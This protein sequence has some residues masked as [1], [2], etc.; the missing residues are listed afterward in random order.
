MSRMK[1]AFVAGPY[2]GKTPWD[3]EQNVRRAECVAF[4]VARAG[5]MPLCPH[6]NTRFFDGTLDDDFWLLGTQELL[7]RCDAVVL[8]EGYEFSSGT[9][10][11][12]KLAEF[13]GIPVYHS[14][15]FPNADIVK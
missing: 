9:L 10:A 13:L 4:E 8:V 3:V 6:T 5:W 2:R 7:R 15:N 1:V 11:E 14:Y 12:I